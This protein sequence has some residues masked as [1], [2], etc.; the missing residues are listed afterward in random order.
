MAQRF[1]HNLTSRQ[2]NVTDLNDFIECIAEGDSVVYTEAGNALIQEFKDKER[3][4][5]WNRWFEY[6][7]NKQD[8][9][10]TVS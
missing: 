4:D 1:Y 2:Y 8:D 9:N 5:L 7:K 3:I 10:T 6:Y